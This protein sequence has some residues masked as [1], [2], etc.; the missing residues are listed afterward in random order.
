MFS[1]EVLNVF[2]CVF[3]LCLILY[4]LPEAPDK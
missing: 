2:V 4:F 1:M 3:V